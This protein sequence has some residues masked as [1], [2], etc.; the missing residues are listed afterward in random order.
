MSYI[1]MNQPWMN[2]ISYSELFGP[3]PSKLSKVPIKM[4]NLGPHP[5]L[6]KAWTFF[7]TKKIFLERYLIYNVVL[8]SGVHTA[9][10]FS[11]IYLYIFFYIYTYIKMYLYVLF[12]IFSPYFLYWVE[13]PVLY[14]RSLVVIYYINIIGYIRGFPGGSVVKNPPANAGDVGWIPGPGRSLGEG[15]GN[16]I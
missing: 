13:F 15:N 1:D 16:P 7:L 11:W 12:Q 2:S 9:E 14:S 6:T 10:W 5:G 3:P 8:V 4:Q